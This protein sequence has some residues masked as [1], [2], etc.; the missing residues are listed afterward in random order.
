MSRDSNL[1]LDLPIASSPSSSPTLNSGSSEQ[2]SAGNTSR[3]TE[4]RSQSERLGR[5]GLAAL[6]Q[7]LSERD[8]AILRSIAEHRF[9]TTK[10]VEQLHFT[11]HATPS[12]AARS[13]RYVLRRLQDLRVIRSLDRRVGGLRA[14]SASFVWTTA[15]VGR[16]LLDLSATN[17][18][19]RHAE[20]SERFLQ[21][22]LAIAAT[23]LSLIA[24][25][26]GG[27]TELLTVELEPAC[28]RPFLAASGSQAVLQPDLMVTT[29]AGNYEDAW[30]IEVD[31]GTEHLPTL[32]RKCEH[33]QTY[34]AT[35]IEQHRHG[36]FPWVVWLLSTE[37]R[38]TA[39]SKAIQRKRSIDAELFKITTPSGLIPLMTTNEKGGVY[40]P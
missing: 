5:H 14:G 18:S 21:H 25:A 31:L 40:A 2:L 34:R 3:P 20:P 19:R 16:R 15:A 29:G 7:E 1:P 33:Y 8:W 28:W 26:R 35:G 37:A 24:A 4:S 11:N 12:S 13:C 38:A 9:L 39:L 30:F 23:H 27:D 22:S 6:Q 10:Q 32:L 36:G 17:P